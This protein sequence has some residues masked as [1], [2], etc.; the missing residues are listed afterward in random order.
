MADNNSHHFRDKDKLLRNVA[1]GK[2]SQF[3]RDSLKLKLCIDDT[4]YQQKQA[5]INDLINFYVENNK[6]YDEEIKYTEKRV[7]KL[8]KEKKA[9]NL[10]ISDLKKNLNEIM[11][12]IETKKQLIKDNDTIKHK[13]ETARTLIKNILITRNDVGA[14][15]VNIDYLVKYGNFE[16][17]KEFSIFVQEYIKDNIKVDDIILDNILKEEDIEY[18]KTIA[19][20]RMLI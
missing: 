14:D 20:K 16:N 18:I 10:K 9:N 11:D 1:E 12:Q 13:N 5:S 3:I 6:M 8:K 2:K 4:A 7:E 19:R 17:K 15:P